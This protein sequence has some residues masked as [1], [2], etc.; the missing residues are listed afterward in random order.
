MALVFLSYDRD[1]AARARPIALT[2]E[3]AGHV[4]WWN[5]CKQEAPG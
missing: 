5:D 4:V 1:D 2:L 3:K